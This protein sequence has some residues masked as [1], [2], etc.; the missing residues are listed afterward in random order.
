M[1][2][3]KIFEDELRGNKRICELVND[4]STLV[5][6]SRLLSVIYLN[7]SQDVIPQDIFDNFVV[8][9]LLHDDNFD[10]IK[11][12]NGLG[13]PLT[14]LRILRYNLIFKKNAYNY[15]KKQAAVKTMQDSRLDFKTVMQ[16]EMK[17]IL[18]KIY[19]RERILCYKVRQERAQ[20]SIEVQSEND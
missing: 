14:L 1:V 11:Q 20:I 16:S 18:D 19:V 7:T 6:L 8:G 4:Q 5:G 15:A 3:I 13:V 2:P 10:K 9:T 12:A 17:A